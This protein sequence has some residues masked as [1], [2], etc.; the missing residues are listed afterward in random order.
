MK[1]KLVQTVLFFQKMKFAKNR[2]VLL[3]KIANENEPS[4]GS[5]FGSDAMVIR[6]QFDGR[7][8]I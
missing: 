7:L 8:V 1:T 3:Y 5:K 6:K 2:N 4:S